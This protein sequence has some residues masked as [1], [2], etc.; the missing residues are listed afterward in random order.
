MARLGGRPE[1]VGERGEARAG[2]ASREQ[3]TG[4]ADRVDDGDGQPPSRELLDLPVEEAEVEAGIVRDEHRVAGVLE[5]PA[6][7]CGRSRC[8]G[9]VG[10]DD[11]GERGDE[12]REPRPGIDER[13]ERASK[14]EAVDANRPDLANPGLPRAEPGRLQVDDH[15]GGRFERELLPRFARE[16]D[17]GA[18]PGQPGVP[19]DDILEEAPREA[20]GRL[21]QGEEMARGL[22]GG[23]R[24]AAL[25][26]ELDETVGGV[27][28]KLHP[29]EDR[30]TY[31]RL[32][33]PARKRR[34]PPRGGPQ[35][36]VRKEGR[37]R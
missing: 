37:A 25:L 31:V 36:F 27:E 19:G 28:G 33:P 2:H 15:K 14:S 17:A 30:R 18:A 35:K 23:D 22:L 4:E 24:P 29:F 11:P 5:E 16:P 34:G 21:P 26:D 20:G 8:A 13:L 9:E 1:E 10:V 3:T 7:G 32:Q 6:Y 12:R